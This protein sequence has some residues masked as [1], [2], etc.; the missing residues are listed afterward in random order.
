VCSY[1]D[2]QPSDMGPHTTFCRCD[3][4]GQ[5]ICPA[6]QL[7]LEETVC[8]PRTGPT[9]LPFG[10]PGVTERMNERLPA[11]PDL[12]KASRVNEVASGG[13]TS[14]CYHGTLGTCQG[15]PLRVGGRAV[16]AARRRGA[17]G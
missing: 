4:S 5:M 8:I 6:S 14:C 13:Q 17:W 12:V 16:V 15:R 1:L 7:G 3:G 9:C 11:C 2:G 10:S